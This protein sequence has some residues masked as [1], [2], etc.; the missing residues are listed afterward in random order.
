MPPSTTPYTRALKRAREQTISNGTMALRRLKGVFEATADRAADIIGTSTSDF[1]V[2]RAAS[3]RQQVVD[4]LESAELKSRAITIQQQQLTVNDVVRIHR[5]A[6]M[7]LAE[8]EL[9]S[10]VGLIARFSDAPARTLAVLAAK[11]SNAANFKTLVNRHLED[12][13]DALD[14]VID[15]AIG[16]GTSARKLA[17]DIADLI[18]G[19]EIKA[20][21]YGLDG[22]DVSGLKTIWYDSRR[23]AVSEINNAYRESNAQALESSGI[24]DA[25]QWQLSGRHHIE[26]DCDELAAGSSDGLPEGYYYLDEWPEAPHPFCLCG[27]G[28][29][30]FKPVE[31]WPG[32]EEAEEEETEEEE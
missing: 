12:A 11:G 5:Q 28:D 2:G 7:K 8:Q 21:I 27:Q 6:T 15:G 18:V 10:T 23:I 4:V 29:V 9:G 14:K 3:I 20:G 22:A 19:E 30:L 25:A 32:A 26:D 16:T 17:K 31:E 13:A 1:A 24:V